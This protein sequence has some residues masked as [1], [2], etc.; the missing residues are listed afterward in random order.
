[1]L[2]LLFLGAGAIGGFLGYWLSP[3]R[4]VIGT[5]AG[6]VLLCFVGVLSTGAWSSVLELWS[7]VGFLAG[8]G[9]G[10]L[11]GRVLVGK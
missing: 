9:L 7:G 10:F 11:G 8:A 2:F 4:R 1:M 3:L 5:L 6:S